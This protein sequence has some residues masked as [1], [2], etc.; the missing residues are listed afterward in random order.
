MVRAGGAQ[1]KRLGLGEDRLGLGDEN[2]FQW[3]GCAGE[4]SG[5]GPR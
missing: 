5:V 3:E 4:V 1:G 2:S